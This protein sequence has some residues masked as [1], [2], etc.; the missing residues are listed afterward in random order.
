MKDYKVKFTR[1]EALLEMMNSGEIDGLTFSNMKKCL[2]ETTPLVYCVY[3]VLLD[4]DIDPKDIITM[5]NDG[6]AIAITFKNKSIP[7]EV[8]EKCN[9]EL[10]R[11]GKKIYRIELKVKDRFLICESKFHKEY[12]ED[13][14]DLN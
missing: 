4:A 14:D 3:T 9:K 5:D 6:E 8:K 2:Y 12:N 13:E 10:V 7:K 1:P 11:Y